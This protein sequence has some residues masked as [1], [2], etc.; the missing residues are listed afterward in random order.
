MEL[1]VSPILLYGA[2]GVGALGVA[3]SMPRARVSPFAIGSIIGAIGVGGLLLGL[4]LANPGQVPNY[5]F[6]LFALIALGGALRVITHTRPVYAALYFVLTI[7][8]SCGLYLLCSAEFLAFALVIVYA[9]AILITYLFVIMLATEGPTGDAVEAMN[10]YDRVSREPV[11]A[12]I[13]GFVILG[14]L[15]TAM[16][17]GTGKLT[18]D[19]VLQSGERA[20]AMLPKKVEKVLRESKD[21]EGKAMLRA[22]ESLAIS[23][24][25][26]RDALVSLNLIKAEEWPRIMPRNAKGDPAFAIDSQSGGG[27]LVLK[28]EKDSLRVLPKSQWPEDL[29]LTNTEGVAFALMDGHPGA[30]EIAGVILLMAMVGAV[31]LARKKVEMDEAA[32]ATA[33]ARVKMAREMGPSLGAEAEFVVPAVGAGAD[34]AAARMGGG[35]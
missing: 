33:A 20:I 21:A 13:A 19:P 23:S 24:D 34:E 29:Y 16:A 1:P 10:E 27:W 31:V 8:A 22:G 12:T 35:R 2:C 17:V 15:T 25:R 26:V 11:M 28:G 14:A 30:I 7:L 4:G 9:G 18:S 6:Y 5:H 32:K 3:L